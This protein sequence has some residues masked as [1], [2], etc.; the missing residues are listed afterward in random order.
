MCTMTL[1]DPIILPLDHQRVDKQVQYDAKCASLC[2]VFALMEQS[3]H[4]QCNSSGSG[5]VV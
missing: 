3:Q 1:L 5:R 4:R 2:L